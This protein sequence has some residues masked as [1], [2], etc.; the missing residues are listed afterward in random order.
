MTAEHLTAVFA[1]LRLDFHLHAEVSDHQA[2]LF[3][4]EIATLELFDGAR[5]SPRGP[6]G[7]LFL[8]FLD[9]PALSTVE[10]AFGHLCAVPGLEK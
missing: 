5:F 7:A 1:F 2:G 8:D 6:R 9:A 4:A 10:L 3:R